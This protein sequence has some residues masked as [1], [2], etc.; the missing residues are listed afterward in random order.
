LTGYH[1]FG[2][3]CP[4]GID[5]YQTLSSYLPFISAIHLGVMASSQEE[6]LFRVIGLGVIQKFV[7]K[8]WVANFLQATIW[9]FLHSTYPQQPCYARGVEISLVGMFSGWIL[10]RYGLIPCL[11]S[12]YVYDAFCD[13][14]PLLTSGQFDLVSTGSLALIPFAIPLIIGLVLVK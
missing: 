5:N 4:L 12:H 1:F 2:F 6:I 9:G 7:R 8:F 11:V 14:R 13:V 3:W 10:R